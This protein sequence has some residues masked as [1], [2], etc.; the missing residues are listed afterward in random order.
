MPKVKITQK[1]TPNYSVQHIEC[2]MANCSKGRSP[3]FLQ[4]IKFFD[5][6]SNDFYNIFKKKKEHNKS[7]CMLIWYSQTCILVETHTQK[8]KTQKLL[9]KPN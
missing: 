2:I 4:F 3:K 7:N 5:V 1:N 6:L 9:K 8:K